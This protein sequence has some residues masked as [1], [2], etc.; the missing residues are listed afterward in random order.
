MH[1]RYYSTKLQVFQEYL[2]PRRVLVVIQVGVALL[3]KEKQD[4]CPAVRE[5]APPY[6]VSAG[7]GGAMLRIPLAV[8]CQASRC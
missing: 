4:K 3:K 2:A 1:H 8:S 5:F 7:D 6:E